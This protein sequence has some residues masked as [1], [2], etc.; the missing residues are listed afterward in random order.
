MERGCDW[1]VSLFIC[2]LLK[3]VHIYMVAVYVK[4]IKKHDQIWSVLLESVGPG[5]LMK[6]CRV[7]T[8]CLWRHGV[9][10]LMQWAA[11]LQM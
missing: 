6:A 3:D 2:L 5:R 1:R 4:A 9:G 10:C 11:L 7:W 8:E